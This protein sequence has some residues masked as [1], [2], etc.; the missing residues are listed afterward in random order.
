[1]D[2]TEDKKTPEPAAALSGDAPPAAPLIEVES[3]GEGTSDAQL[4][5]A[6]RDLMKMQAAIEESQARA[7]LTQERLKD[8]YERFQR[9][10]ADFDNFKKRVTR[11]TEEKVKFANQKLLK[12]LIPVLDNLDRAME[13]AQKATDS[14]GL[15]EGMKL[16]QRSF[17]ETMARN[18]V[19]AQSAVGKPFDPTFMEALMEEETD[20]VGPG[21]VVQ[22]MVKAYFLNDRM[23]RPAAVV[24][25]KAPKKTE[26]APAPEN[27]KEEPA[28]GG[29]GSE[30]E[31]GGGQKN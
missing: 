20:T 23:V 1:M 2:E 17:E 7:R 11:E 22:E 14:A 25:A 21:T 15:L 10:S 13:H 28:K 19:K 18:G 3:E 12:D 16:V 6:R 24:V 8:T 26:A 31:G 30:G 29:A 4:E 27:P 5:E 9:V